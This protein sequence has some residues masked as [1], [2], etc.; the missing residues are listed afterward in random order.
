MCD[1]SSTV[2][3]TR[4]YKTEGFYAFIPIR[5][6]ICM[7]GSLPDVITYAKFRVEIFRGYDFTEGRISH[8]PIDFGM[9]LTT[10]QRDCAAC[11]KQCNT[12]IIANDKAY[13]CH[14]TVLPSQVDNH[15][16]L[17]Y[18]RWH[19]HVHSNLMECTRRISCLASPGDT[20]N[21]THL[22]NNNKNNNYY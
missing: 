3:I 1:V 12:T 11:D 20:F 2:G 7:V 10:V 14:S 9:G 18:Y 4:C 17:A 16:Y 22:R 5:T 8:F 6:K 13:R 21:N 19:A 15:N